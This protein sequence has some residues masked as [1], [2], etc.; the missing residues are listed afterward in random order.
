MPPAREL[1]GRR[2]GDLT[3]L[4]RA[5]VPYGQPRKAFWRCR[6]ACGAET[7][8]PSDRLQRGNT[9]SCGCRRARVTRAAKLRHGHATVG[10]TTPEYI[11]WCRIIA[12]CE[13]P[14]EPSFRDYG[15]R[16]IRMRE[17]YRSDYRTFFRD[18]GP[19][20]SPK[21]SIDRINPL[22]D[23]EPGNIRWATR[24]QQANNTRVNRRITWQGRTQ[25]LSQWNDELG[26]RSRLLN[27]RLRNG[28]SV[29]RA[30]TIPHGG[31]S[32]QRA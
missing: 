31:Y 12:R 8:V 16:G 32:R 29:E 25:T 11:T 10:A 18:V 28:W 24:K 17:P 1:V 22:G 4:M 2:F 15:A 9:K 27:H 13:N 23:Y 26:F 6:C 5:P 3:V 7:I 20:P 19:R 30:M 21:H 14:K